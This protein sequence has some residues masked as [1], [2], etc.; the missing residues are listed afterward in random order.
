MGLLK[1]RIINIIIEKC[2][3]EEQYYIYLGVSQNQLYQN[4]YYFTMR[5]ATTQAL[6]R[7]S[8]LTR[9]DSAICSEISVVI[10]GTKRHKE[11]LVE[12]NYEIRSDF[13]TNS[14]V[15]QASVHYLVTCMLT[16]SHLKCRVSGIESR[17]IREEADK[18][19]K[20]WAN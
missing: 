10:R 12:R 7:S 1:I 11:D 8:I 5:C 18:G 6:Y 3:F 15:K 9:S 4:C 20:G 2:Y 13:G 19:L 14:Q 17:P 16:E